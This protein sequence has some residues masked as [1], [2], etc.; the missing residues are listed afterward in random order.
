MAEAGLA[1]VKIEPSTPKIENDIERSCLYVKS[2]VFKPR[3]PV[4]AHQYAQAR[5]GHLGTIGSPNNHN[6][7]YYASNGHANELF[8]NSGIDDNNQDVLLAQ[9]LAAQDLT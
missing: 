1:A 8:N 3:Q 7:P 4:V 5:K 9:I 2:G 6:G